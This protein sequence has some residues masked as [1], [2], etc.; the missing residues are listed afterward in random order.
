MVLQMD[1]ELTLE[2]LGLYATMVNRFDANGVGAEYLASLSTDSVEKVNELLEGLMV[3]G[4]V[5]KVKNIYIAD[6]TK[7]GKYLR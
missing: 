1:K 5:R 6:V 4:Y 7:A 2:E 3:K